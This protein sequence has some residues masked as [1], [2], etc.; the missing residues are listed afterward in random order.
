[1]EMRAKRLS[2]WLDENAWSQAELARLAGISAG[3]VK[4][5]IAGETVTRHTANAIVAALD[6]AYQAKRLTVRA[7][8]VTLASIKGMQITRLERKKPKKSDQPGA[9]APRQLAGISAGS[10]EAQHPGEND[11]EQH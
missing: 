11:P 9:P 7:D 8:H 3:A 2:A 4:R 1:M 6:D 5:A 10:G